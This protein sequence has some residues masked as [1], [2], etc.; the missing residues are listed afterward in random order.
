MLFRCNIFSYGVLIKGQKETIDE[1]TKSCIDE[2]KKILDYEKL[3]LNPK[4]GIFDLKQGVDFVGYR[5]WKNK[6]LIRKQSL[7]RIRKSLKKGFNQ[8]RV[9]SFLSHAKDTNSLHYVQ[10]IINQYKE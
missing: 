2:I 3:R 4:S 9:H 1:N 8:N 7:F 6:R 10:N 5:T